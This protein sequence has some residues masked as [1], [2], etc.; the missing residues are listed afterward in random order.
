MSITVRLWSKEDLE[1]IKHNKD[2]LLTTIFMNAK[3]FSEEEINAY[4]YTLRKAYDV[5]F[6]NEIE[7]IQVYATDDNTLK[8]FLRLEYH[9][10]KIVS[11][12]ELITEVREVK[13]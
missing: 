10:N 4:P 5:Y 11:I 13:V 12:G 9:Y 8:E 3:A 1:K 7:P 6:E 2:K